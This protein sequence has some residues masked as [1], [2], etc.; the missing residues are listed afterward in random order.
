MPTDA[1]THPT[2]IC[3]FLQMFLL[4]QLITQVKFPAVP[5][6]DV[7]DIFVKGANLQCQSG[8][9]LMN[10]PIDQVSCHKKKPNLAEKEDGNVVTVS[11]HVFQCIPNVNMPVKVKFLISKLQCQFSDE[12][13]KILIEDSCAV[14]YSLEERRRRGTSSM[15]YD[16]L[17]WCI[18]SVIL[19]YLLYLVAMEYER[20]RKLS[21]W[22][23]PSV[24]EA[25]SDLEGASNYNRE[26][27]A[28]M[29]DERVASYRSEMKFEQGHSLIMD[30][31][32]ARSRS[33]RRRVNDND[34]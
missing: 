25:I 16:A 18:L 6:A 33:R 10:G 5:V 15:M 28:G 21:Q 29:N 26:T 13:K 32:R 1:M 23:A 8:C 9:E 27:W 7:T 19:V 30:R 12:A 24:V 17:L 34:Y 3:F 20:K 2:P 11:H 14:Y 31:R 4:Y 22:K